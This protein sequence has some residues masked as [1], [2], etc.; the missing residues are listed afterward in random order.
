[1]QHLNEPVE[2]YLAFICVLLATTLT[3]YIPMKGKTMQYQGLLCL[4]QT[5]VVLS[6][7]VTDPMKSHWYLL[8]NAKQFSVKSLRTNIMLVNPFPVI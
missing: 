5:C 8:P 7:Q 1:M 4:K 2:Q 6:I 3:F